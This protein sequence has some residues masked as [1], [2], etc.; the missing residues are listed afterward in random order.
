MKLHEKAVA[1]VLLL[2][3]LLTG[4]SGNTKKANKTSSEPKVTLENP[5]LL[6][7][8]FDCDYPE[9]EYSD[10]YVLSEDESDI[11][12]K[13]MYFYADFDMIAGEVLHV[14]IKGDCSEDCN[15]E[16]YLFESNGTFMWDKGTKIERERMS[17][18]NGSDVY[19]EVTLDLGSCNFDDQYDI[20]IAEDT[21]VLAH[22]ALYYED[23]A[24]DKPVIYL[25]PEEEMN[26]TVDLNFAGEITCTY[27]EINDGWNVLASP[28]GTLYNLEDGRYYD[29]LFW[30]GEISTYWPMDNAACVPGSETATFLE[31]YLTAAG[32]NDS[33]ID[34]FISFWLPRM[35]NN[36]YNLIAFQQEA[37][38]DLAELNISPKPDS[39]LRIYMTF[40]ALDEP[41]ES[42]ITMPEPFIRD[43]FTVVEWG[44]SELVK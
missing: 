2:T 19:S 21:T 15:L 4:C 13:S 6:V 12:I 26:V 11:A 25:Y 14:G 5:N 31:G 17:L 7:G 38:T 42:E 23:V 22:A 43:G 33:E 8:R 29:Y 35:Q 30:E 39:E 24:V 28:D 40:E 32:L 16:V 18:T 10:G 34:D 41:V 1:S 3:V 36:P 9:R 20:V 44:G 27:P 37:Y